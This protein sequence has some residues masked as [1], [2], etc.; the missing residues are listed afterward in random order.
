[1]LDTYSMAQQ[2]SGEYKD[3]FEKADMY[4]A[5]NADSLDDMNE[6]L[7]DLYDILVEAQHEGKPVEKII[8]NDVEEFCRNF[9]WEEKSEGKLAKTLVSLYGAMKMVLILTLLDVFLLG[10]SGEKLSMQSDIVPY[11]GGMVAG[12]ILSIIFKEWLQPLIFKKKKIK[13]IV[14]Y[15]IILFLFIGS[16]VIVI[17]I[18]DGKELGVSSLLLILV[19]GI[20]VA[21]YLVARSIWRYKKYGRITKFDKNEKKNAKRIE[22]EFN[23]EIFDKNLMSSSA[24]EMVNR[25]KKMNKK[26]LK[27]EQQEL[28]HKE[29]AKKVRS[30]EEK[31]GVRE[32][33]V[34]I[35]LFGIAIAATM[36]EILNSAIVDGLIYGA[37]IIIF[38]FMFYRSYC[39]SSR[40]LSKVRLAVLKECD[41]LG[42]GIIEYV[43]MN[44]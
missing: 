16:I 30:E 3:V 10:E 8:G 39:K 31:V 25:F 35:V 4:S 20:Y 5:T 24:K 12:W 13:P 1:M 33:G 32:K 14:Y 41:E 26:K 40:Q 6:K 28:T 38:E 43:D 19:S 27:R 22:K 42:V 15:L 37:V 23:D 2:L 34:A 29:F 21:V 7:M 9:F 18:T 17:K 36:F 11:I 44:K